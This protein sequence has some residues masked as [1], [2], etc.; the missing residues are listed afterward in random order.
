MGIQRRRNGVG[1]GG[2]PGQRV[3]A[4]SGDGV[5]AV[6]KIVGS[7]HVVTQHVPSLLTILLGVLEPGLV[8]AERFVVLRLLG[9]DVDRLWIVTRKVGGVGV[10]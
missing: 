6:V 2:Y 10:Q 5:L 3:L 9:L 7:H 1:H 4:V 8:V